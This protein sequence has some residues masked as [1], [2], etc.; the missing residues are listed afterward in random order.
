[1]AKLSG[2]ARRI[3]H[4]GARGGTFGD[5]QN[6]HAVT[7]ASV[8]RRGA[9]DTDDFVIGMGGDR[10]DGL[11]HFRRNCSRKCRRAG[12]SRLLRMRAATRH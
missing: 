2:A 5:D 12:S 6:L 3:A 7:V 10:E 11:R 4:R 1:M 9:T 8:S